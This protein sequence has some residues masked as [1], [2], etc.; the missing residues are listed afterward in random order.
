MKQSDVSSRSIAVRFSQLKLFSV[1]LGIPLVLMSSAAYAQLSS[2]SVNGTVKD[3]SGAVIPGANVNIRATAT[4]VSRTAAT[5]NAGDY[6]FVDLDPGSYTLEVSKNGFSTAQQSAVTLSVNQTATF[7]FTLNVGSEVEKV[8]VTGATVQLETAVSNLGT[9]FNPV[10][11]NDLP[12]NGRNFTQLLTLT[13]GSGAKNTS[14]NSGAGG[15]QGIFTGSLSFPAVNGQWNRSNLF[16]LDGINNQMAFYSEYAVPPIV[17]AIEEFK[18]QSHNDQGQFGGALGGIV[19]VVTKSGSNQ[20][21]GNVWEF[22][23]NDAFDAR[24]PLLTKKTPLKQSVYG[25]TVGG[26]VIFPH[27]NGRNRTFFFGAYEG[28]N[29][30]SANET[31]YNV[32]TPAELNGNFSGVSTQLYNPFSTRPDPARPGQFLR[33]PF[34][35]NNI[36]SSLDPNMVKLAKDIF[37]A[38]IATRSN[39]N[40]EDTQA[41][42]VRQNNYSFRLDEQLSQSNLIW[43]R[44][45]Q[46]HTTQTSGAGFVGL[47]TNSVSNAQNWA[48]SFVHTF[49]ASATLQIQAGHVWQRYKTISTLTNAPS[50]V[51]ADSGFNNNFVCNYIGSLPCQ[52]PVLAITG[53]LT[54]GENYGDATGSDIYEYKADYTRLLGRHVIELGTYISPQSNRVIQANPNLGFSSFQTSNPESSANSGDAMASFLLGV[55]STAERRNLLKLLGGGQIDGF[56]FQ[57]QW[58]I[59]PKLTMNW[60]FRYDILIEEGLQASPTLSNYSGAYNMRTGTY[61]LTKDAGK[62]PSCSVSPA[63]PCIP[64]GV[65]PANVTVAKSN[66]LI[67]N[68]YDNIQPRLGFAYQLTPRRVLHLSYGRVFD[69]WSSLTQAVQNEGALWPS[70]GLQTANNLNSTTV[71][72]S[73]EDPLALGNQPTVLP[74]ATPFGQVAFF[75]A[76]YLR[77]PYSDQWLAG[78]QQ[79]LGSSSIWTLNYVGSRTTRLPCCDYYNVALTPGPGTPPQARAIFPYI[80]PTHYEQNNGSSSYNSLQTQLQRQFTGGLSY[81]VNYTW[82]KAINVACDGAFGVEGCFVRNPYNPKADRSVAG[83]D[84]TNMFTGTLLYQLPFGTGQRF[85]S[86]SRVV[87]AIAGGWQLNT[88]TTLTSGAPFTVTYSG[89]RANTGNDFQGVDLVGNPYLA[90]PSQKEWFNT[91]AFQTPAQYT[92][93]NAGRNIL[94]SQWFRDVD[95]SLFRTFSVER[96]KIEFRA[97]AFNGFNMPVLGAPQTTLNSATFGQVL[98]TASTQR[99]LQLALKIYF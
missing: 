98:T 73:A 37:P 28:T 51:I 31:L 75:V 61:I 74:A 99:E 55:P 72:R 56:Y 15:V 95:F 68:D 43:G 65:L 94:R 34:A 36:S 78:I 44:L 32:P 80:T 18:M 86:G 35:G 50:T 77:N 88:I 91:A 42:E 83:F 19:N 93:G 39:V 82:S 40:G 52:I 49:G 90:N 71:T 87:N 81:T 62:A 11:M 22:L 23:R 47:E 3:P 27:Y 48:A 63:S 84:L 38:P 30:N 17:D 79:Q 10:A 64:N 29:I 4:G 1:L 13:P 57:D 8:T 5:N 58:K 14:Q 16:L 92:Y 67:N 24:N 9:V 21:H 25:A 7:N 20:F 60:G 85:Q 66:K 45:S 33:T 96:A 89:D 53:Y 97:E 26:P 2:A 69:T 54:G 59:T 76:P 46:V 6:A 12:L 70:V 41:T